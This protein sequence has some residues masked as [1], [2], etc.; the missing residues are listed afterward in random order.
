MKK[1]KMKKISIFALL[2]TFISCNIDDGVNP[3]F[4]PIHIE[5]VNI[6]QSYMSGYGIQGIPESNLVIDNDDDWNSLLTKMDSYNTITD[7]FTTT[8]IDFSTNIIIAVFLEVKPS[9][10]AVEID[11]II[12]YEDAIV[13]STFET[14]TV[15]TAISQPFHIVKIPKTSKPIVF[16]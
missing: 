13:V 7:S 12:E 11:E 3:P 15:L 10:W 8:T 14:I 2:F 5:F 1:L 6:R 4:E 16:E 9:I